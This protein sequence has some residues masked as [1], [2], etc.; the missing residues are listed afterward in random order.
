MVKRSSLSAV[1]LSLFLL[2]GCVNTPTEMVQTRDDRPFIMFSAVRPGDQVI[3]DGINMGPASD[4]IAGK[5]GMRI[6]P[7]THKLQIRRAGKIVFKQKFYAADGVSKTFTI[8]GD[9]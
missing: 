5:S 7:G 9:Q 2:G 3:L 1:A 6:E 8:G 4:Y